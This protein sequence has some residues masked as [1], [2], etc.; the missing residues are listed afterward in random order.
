MK[1]HPLLEYAKE[2]NIE[3]YWA[4]FPAVLFSIERANSTVILTF[5]STFQGKE[6]G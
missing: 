1:G 5:Y 4:V 3:S 2:T 6:V